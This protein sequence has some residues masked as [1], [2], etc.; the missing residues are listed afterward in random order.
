MT[1]MLSLLLISSSVRAD[2][3]L[4]PPS[5][6]ASKAHATAP[7]IPSIREADPRRAPWPGP[8]DEGWSPDGEHDSRTPPADSDAPAFSGETIDA[9]MGRLLSKAFPAARL[10]HSRR[11]SSRWSDWDFEVWEERQ[12]HISFV[13]RQNTREIAGIQVSVSGSADERCWSNSRGAYRR[14]MPTFRGSRMALFADAQPWEREIEK[15]VRD[16]FRGATE[17][18]EAMR[19][20]FLGRSGLRARIRTG[21]DTSD[22][23][24]GS[25]ST[26]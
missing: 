16:A 26:E 14:S 20:S 10:R 24:N 6:A 2:P 23:D 4:T 3:G 15:A 9:L 18:F 5:G 22:F 17:E 19:S 21:V 8:G 1:A 13:T 12:V 11:S 7:E 25:D